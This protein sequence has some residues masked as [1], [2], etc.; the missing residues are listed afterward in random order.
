[1]PGSLVQCKATNKRAPGSYLNKG[2]IVEYGE[3]HHFQ[4][5]IEILGASTM[6]HQLLSYL[7]PQRPRRV[8]G[9][10]G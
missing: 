8:A 1:M 3:Q 6:P 9:F 5:L 10:D 4:H 2:S 7:G